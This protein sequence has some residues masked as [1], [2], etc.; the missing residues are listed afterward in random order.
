MKAGF[1]GYRNFAGKLRTLFEENGSVSSFLLYHPNKNIK[2]VSSTNKLKDLCCCDFIVIASPDRTHADY[3][4][5]LIN[6]EGYIFCEKIPVLTRKDLNFLKENPNPKLYFNFNYRK[7]ILYD[8]LNEHQEEILYIHHCCGNGFALTD[9]YADNWRSDKI[10]APLGVFQLSGV[11]FFDL[12]LFCYGRPDSYHFNSRTV[13]KHG[14]SIDNF[15][16]SLKFNNGIVANLYFSYTSPFHYHFK[17]TTT[18]QVLT[19]DGK[20]LN[21]NG[22][23]DYFDENERFASP[24]LTSSKTLDIYNESLK[25]SVDYFIEISKCGDKFNHEN[26]RNN[27]LST[28]IFLDI[29][30]EFKSRDIC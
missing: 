3:L 30:D 18:E 8:I 22:P 19:Y 2:G 17:I 20:M 16:I 21:I 5:K 25:K 7:S 28:E 24:P 15:E 1:I 9:R 27:L 26:S 29:L 23:R 6:Y 14:N 11:H 13:S 10:S 4:R 12:L